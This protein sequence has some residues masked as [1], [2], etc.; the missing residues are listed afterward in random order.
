MIIDELNTSFTKYK[1][2]QQN[3]ILAIKKVAAIDYT[4]ASKIFSISEFDIHIIKQIKEKDAILT[5]IKNSQL[6]TITTPELN[7]VNSILERKVLATLDAHDDEV[8]NAVVEYAY[9]QRSAILNI[10]RF[11]T[12]GGDITP[13]CFDISDKSI[14]FI[15]MFDEETLLDLADKY[16]W[17][18]RMNYTKRDDIF[19]ESAELLQH[20]NHYVESTL[21]YIESA[22]LN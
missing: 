2:C 13:I 22:P 11:I 12:A 9:A 10:K 17:L 8:K 3:A 21:N 7:E 1:T 5:S 19:Y 18:F 20:Q 16:T 4:L 14:E 6:F 15:K